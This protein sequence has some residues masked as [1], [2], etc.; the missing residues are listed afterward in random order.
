M[1]SPY[2][3][4]GR[5]SKRAPAIT[6]S[7]PPTMP[8]IVA[9]MRTRRRT[10]R[11]G[12]IES[13]T[14]AIGDSVSSRNDLRPDLPGVGPGYEPVHAVDPHAL[15]VEQAERLLAMRVLEAE[16]HAAVGAQISRTGNQLRGESTSRQHGFRS[17]RIVRGEKRD[18][19][20]HATFREAH[21]ASSRSAAAAVRI[22]SAVLN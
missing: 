21:D 3:S 16:R 9:V 18:Q 8:V 22:S 7:S 15:G 14:V 17:Q 2:A 10:L 6:A 20:V 4:G 12:A 19:T 5:T 11:L 1:Q 13:T